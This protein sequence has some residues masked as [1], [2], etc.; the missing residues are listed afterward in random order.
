MNKLFEKINKNQVYFIAEIGLN[1]NGSLEIAKE[2]IE[3][4]YRS[5]VDAVKFQK[6]DVDL[7]AT[8]T[9]LNQFD[10]RFPEFG[11]TYGDIRRHLEFSIDEL[12]HLKE[13]A[14]SK[15][16]DFF[17]TPFDIKSLEEIDKLNL[18]IIKIASHS[19]TNLDLLYEI[20]E[21]KVNTIL[22]TGMC[23]LDEID[24][25]LRIL[26]PVRD[27]LIL[28]HCVSSYPT[29]NINANLNVIDTLRERYKLPIGYS[30]HEVDTLP[31]LMAISKGAC[32]IERHI[33]LNKNMIG[34]DHKLSLDENDL[35][36]LINE[37]NRYMEILGSGEKK[38]NEYEMVTREK[39]RVSMVSKRY[40]PKDSRLTIED[41]IWKNPGTG[42]G[43]RDIDKY[44]GKVLKNDIQED[45]L[46][47][48]EDFYD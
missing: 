30:G 31:T 12:I 16:L 6:R 23:N 40:L 21:R 2:L 3:V 26:K 27:R 19:V 43:R 42:I 41:I 24:E 11:S 35:R 1:H 22:S 10:D 25:A 46:I 15:G 44:V 32:V 18:E 13:I 17:V 45:S 29:E 8:K 48:R 4:A 36:L 34:F 28:L 37:V 5:K 14:E 38:L 33:T 20:S 39:Y 9:V 47:K 7:L